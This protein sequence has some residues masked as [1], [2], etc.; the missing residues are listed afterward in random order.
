LRCAGVDDDRALGPAFDEVDEID[1]TFT[2][3]EIHQL[4]LDRFPVG[5][6]YV[7]YRRVRLDEERLAV[8]GM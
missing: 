2:F 8:V 3:I 7:G 6:E 4:S 5:F 1:A